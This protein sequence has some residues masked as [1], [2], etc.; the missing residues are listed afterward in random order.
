[1]KRLVAITHEGALY[2]LMRSTLL[3]DKRRAGMMRTFQ[4]L[5]L[6]RERRYELRPTLPS[7]RGKAAERRFREWA[8][9]K[10]HEV[11][12]VTAG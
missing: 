2:E 11:R 3:I 10:G 12:E 5:G 1:M 9:A 7:G 8:A 4:V 6:G